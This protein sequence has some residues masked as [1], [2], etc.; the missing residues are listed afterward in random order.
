MVLKGSVQ[1]GT[2]LLRAGPEQASPTLPRRSLNPGARRPGLQPHPRRCPSK[3]GGVRQGYWM[4]ISRPW[5]CCRN[6]YPAERFPQGHSRSGQGHQQPG[7]LPRFSKGS[8]A[9]LW[10]SISSAWTWSCTYVSPRNAT[11]EGHPQLAITLNNLG[12]LDQTQGEYSKAQEFYQQALDM[13]RQLYPAKRYPQGHEDPGPQP[14]Q[15]GWCPS[16]TKASTA[17]RWNST[18]NPWT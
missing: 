3:S 13:L 17:R 5:T 9:R 8:T 10:N 12:F 14:Q 15:S 7:L 1:Q 16:R 6:L 2:G 11:P 4:L 18:N